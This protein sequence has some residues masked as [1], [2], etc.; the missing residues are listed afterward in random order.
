MYHKGVALDNTHDTVK[1]NEWYLQALRKDPALLIAAINIAAVQ[2]SGRA[3]GCRA[4][5][6]LEALAQAR[7]TCTCAQ[8][9]RGWAFNLPGRLAGGR[10]LRWEL[11]KEV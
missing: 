5:G 2:A 1:A 11:P 7:L 3:L 4:G 10:E 6:R 8:L 9:S